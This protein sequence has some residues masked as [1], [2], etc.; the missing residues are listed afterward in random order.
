[1]TLTHGQRTRLIHSTRKLGA[2]LGETPTIEV[3]KPA[4]RPGSRPSTASSTKS[5]SS[6]R[7]LLTITIPTATLDYSAQR[8]PLSPTYNLNRDSPYNPLSPSTG[9]PDRSVLNAV[10]LKRKKVAKLA[11]TFGE[12]VPPE[13]V[14]IG[15]YDDLLSRPET[16]VLGFDRPPSQA[17]DTS[18]ESSPLIK[19]AP[20]SLRARRG[21]KDQRPSQS[22]VLKSPRR[23]HHHTASVAESPRRNSDKDLAFAKL[24]QRPATSEGHTKI[25]QTRRRQAGWS[26]EWNEGDMKKVVKRLRNLK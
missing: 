1:M 13:L 5:T 18:S 25:D 2:L 11:R 12:N 23:T 16:H 9:T 21:S 17:S 8:S 24:T 26:G 20:L 22:H 6:T 3:E 10:E 15:T 19:P 14:T 4:S 7:S